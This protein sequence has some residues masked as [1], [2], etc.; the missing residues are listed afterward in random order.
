MDS[1]TLL[2]TAV[3]AQMVTFAG[4]VVGL[5][6]GYLRDG[7]TRLWLKEDRA[8]LAQQ[9]VATAKDLDD[10]AIITAKNLAD[11]TTLKSD[12]LRDLALGKADQAIEKLTAIAADVKDAKNAADSAFSEAN[13]VNLKLERLGLE[14]KK[15][16]AE[17]FAL[18]VAAGVAEALARRV[19]E[20][21]AAGRRMG[22]KGP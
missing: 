5:L 21:Q 7:R 14:H 18:L 8:Y 4:V 1:D 10:K 3:V 9:A 15:A 12:G 6:F 11:H 2:I 19:V 13:H 16:D 17:Q 20:A 22:D